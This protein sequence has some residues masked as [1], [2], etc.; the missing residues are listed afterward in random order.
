[1]NKLK[2]SALLLSGALSLN[3]QNDTICTGITQ[4]KVFEFDY[5]ASKII[6]AKDVDSV[7]TIKVSPNEVLCLHLFTEKRKKYKTVFLFDDGDYFVD[8]LQSKDNTY[9]F[10]GPVD[11][12]VYTK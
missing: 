10:T 6:D 9:Y 8:F 11:V 4:E 5:S 12:I 2:L 1:M 3:A 7:Y